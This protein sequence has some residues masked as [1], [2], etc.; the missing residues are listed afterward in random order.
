[1][2]TKEGK[3]LAHPQERVPVGHAERDP[4]A[5]GGE[6]RGRW[7]VASVRYRAPPSLMTLVFLSS[8][9][10][11]GPAEGGRPEPKAQAAPHGGR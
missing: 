9:H 1:M 6:V 3:R 10:G 7:A 8:A 11:H 2:G 4:A 5:L